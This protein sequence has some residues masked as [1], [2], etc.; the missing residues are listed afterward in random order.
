ML[1]NVH[2][3]SSDAMGP[4]AS[5]ALHAA[6]G[7]YLIAAMLA[8][9]ALLLPSKLKMTAADIVG[10]ISTAALAVY[11]AARF[12]EAGTQP[13][14]SMFEIIALSALFL[15]LA[16]FVAM[17]IRRLPSVGAFAFPALS[18][19][20]LVGYLFALRFPPGAQTGPEQP[21]LVVHI[22]LII[23][24]YGVYFMAAVAAA[25]YLLQER[26]LKLHREPRYTRNF[27][28]LEALNKLVATCVQ[29]GLPLLTIGFALGFAAFTREDWAQIG[30]NS[31]V[32]SG[33]V[34]WLVLVGISVGRFTGY[35][36][37]RRHYY[38]VLV[39]FALVLLTFVGLGLYTAAQ[40]PK[41]H[42]STVAREAR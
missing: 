17:A 19:I 28:S 21:L 35:L 1:A 7:G 33:V 40:G 24:S 30:T 39:G 23:L 11:F 32:L 14:G 41:A 13:L 12:A 42:V 15:A 20:F 16:Y 6:I 9:G 36:H 26:Q 8:V 29:I 25:M 18:V 38:W 5:V 2:S 4:L 22:V 27:P 3:F 37:G 10:G 34:L 31:K